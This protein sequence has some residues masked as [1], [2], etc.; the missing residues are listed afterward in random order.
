MTEREERFVRVASAR[1]ENVLQAMEKL[2]RCADRHMYEYRADQAEQI[3][4]AIREQLTMLEQLFQSATGCRK[5]F[6]LLSEEEQHED[7]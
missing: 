4:S 7:A 5:K 6:T 1:T 2:G 3:I